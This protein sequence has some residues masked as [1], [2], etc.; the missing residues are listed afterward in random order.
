MAIATKATRGAV[1]TNNWTNPANATADDGSYATAAPGKNG[2]VIGDWDFAAFTDGEIPVGA[3]INSVTIR[4]Q[5]KV[6][7]TSSIASLGVQAGNNAVFDT[8]ETHTAEPTTDFNFDIVYN[9]TPSIT[10]LKTA[11]RLVARDRAI[12]GNSN[13][14]VTFSLDYVELRVDYTPSQTFFQTIAATAVGIPSV[15]KGMFKTL[16]ASAVGAAALDTALLSSVS[17]PA[18]ALG[19]P[20][21]SKT[22]IFT[23]LITATAIATASLAKKM[24]VS[25]SATSVGVPSLLKKMFRSVSATAVAL[26]SVSSSA[27]FAQ[28]IAAQ[29]VGIASLTAQ[30]IAGG[31]KQLYQKVKIALGI[32]L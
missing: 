11:G 10:D 21:L 27:T 6:S 20:S 32:G 16:A 2:S 25:V 31:S 5:Y 8:E 13:N 4:S 17:I 14:A 9:T 28:S 30:F 26:P 24:F 29:A 7:T 12:R 18:I 1:G 23:E 19:V 3:T 15:K 22:P